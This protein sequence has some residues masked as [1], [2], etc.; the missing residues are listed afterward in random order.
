MFLVSQGGIVRK[1][2]GFQALMSKKTKAN[3]LHPPL[4]IMFVCG[5]VP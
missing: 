2:K 4:D 1:G 3:I 5:L